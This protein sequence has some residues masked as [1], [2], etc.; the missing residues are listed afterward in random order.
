MSATCGERRKPMSR[1]EVL[2]EV[3]WLLDGGVHPLLIA[4]TLGRSVGAIEKA[5]RDLGNARVREAFTQPVVEA[6]YR[7]ERARA[8]T[9]GAQVAA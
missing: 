5:A 2:V 8:R 1:A 6:R 7:R 3:E 9:T 4:Q